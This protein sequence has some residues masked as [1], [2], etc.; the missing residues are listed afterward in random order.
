MSEKPRETFA[1]RLGFIFLSAG[2]AIGLGNVWRFPFITGQYGGAAF[3]LI[4]IL[5][6][7]FLAMPIMVMEFAVGRA[8]GQSMSRSFAVLC[9]EHKVWSLWGYIGWAGNYVLMMFYTVVNGWMIAYTY[10]SFSGKLDGLNAEA[11]GNVFGGMLANP[12]ELTF[13]MAVVIV[14]GALVCWAGLQSGVESITKAMMCGLLLLMIVLAGRSVT[15]EGADKGLEFYLKPDFTKLFTN[16]EGNFS[17]K[18]L[19]TTLYA[20]LGQAFF[21]LSIGIGSMAIFGSYIKRDRSL[22]GESVI[23]TA[24]DTFVALMAGLIIFPAC[25]AYGINPG[26]G[27]GLIFVTLPN[28]FNQMPNGRV[29]G[30]LFFLFLSFAALS[31]VI[32][33][34]ENI[35]ACFMDRF[36]MNRH[37]AVSVMFVT[38]IFLS[39]PCALGFNVWSDFQPLGPGSG[40]LDLEDFIVSNNLLPIG[41]LVYLSFCVTRYGWGWD[42]FI[43]EA[44]TGK[45]LKFPQSMRFFFTFIVPLV[46]LLI[47]GVGYYQTFAK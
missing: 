4:Y 27:P 43:V 37:K 29:W 21:T 19:G 46:I 6:L 39:I 12:Y 2:C 34:F 45:G 26:A 35:V 14:L 5:F 44:D 8:S 11:V 32:A 25:F 1:S 31:T 9:P 41:A 33:V 17:M 42:K 15:L 3:V 28:M 20:A 40:V 22:L 10:Y 30:A 13:W 7:L 47:L 24:L 36:G 38:I 18:H 23:I 16:P